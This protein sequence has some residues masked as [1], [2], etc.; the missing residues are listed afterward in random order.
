MRTFLILILCICCILLGCKNEYKKEVAIE[1]KTYSYESI[2]YPQANIEIPDSLRNEFIKR[3]F[4]PWESTPDALLSSLD[5]LPGKELSYLDKYLKDDEWYGEN[6]KPHKKWQREQVVNNVDFLS[7]P[8]FQKKGIVIAHTDLRRIPTNRPGFDTY[9]KAGEGYPF[10]YFQETALWANTPVFIAHTSKDRQWGYVISPYYKG[11]VSM[12]DMAI[13]DED[14]IEQWSSKSFCLPLSDNVNLKNSDSNYAINAKIGMVLP[15]EEVSNTPGKVTVYYT[16]ANENQNARILK[17][18]IN[19]DAVAFS[20]FLFNEKTLKQLVSNLVERPYGWGGNLEN[21]DCS[22]M[23]R[24]L[25][26]S[27]RIWLP[28]DSGDQIDVGHKYELPESTEEKVKLIQEK[29]IPFLTILRKKGHNMLYVG[30]SPEGEPLILH[31]IWGLKTSYSNDQLVNYLST[32]P[33]E[34]LHQDEDGSIRGRHIIGESVI[35]SVH[36]GTGNDD[37][38]IPLIEEMYAMT[39]ILE[40]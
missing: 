17:A 22:S 40:D 2:K 27:Y 16:N 30:D 36:A 23:I 11:W 20:N 4:V 14:F 15:Y 10:D 28:R 39:N 35:T 8:N 24:D 1:V 3:F 6:K 31:A 37:V 12:H 18:E 5:R 34:G 19:K 25:L 33:V 29:G 26:G 13:V 32:Y 9:S 7:Y 21:R 38:T